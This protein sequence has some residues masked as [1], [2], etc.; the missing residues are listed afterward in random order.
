MSSVWGS[1]FP[2][3]GT[4]GCGF[5]IGTNSLG[6]EQHGERMGA[7]LTLASREANYCTVTRVRSK[8]VGAITKEGAATSRAA[9]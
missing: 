2:E 7:E 9:Q 1:V 8:E 3:L 6:L 4:E 5:S